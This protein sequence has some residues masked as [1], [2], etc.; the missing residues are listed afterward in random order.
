ML[1]Q[2][3]I[4]NYALIK[5]LSI[6]PDQGLNIVTGE[7]GAGKSIMLGALG[8]LL[9]KRADTKVLFDNSRKCVIEGIFDV[10]EYRLKA[11]FDEFDVDYDTECILRREISSSGKSRAFVNDGVV[12]LDFLKQLGASLMDIHSQHDTLL[13]GTNT[14]QL[15]LID[16]FAQNAD[17][18]DSYALQYQ[19]YQEKKSIHEQLVHESAEL[20][21][22]ADY[23]QFLFDELEKGNFQAGEQEE[24]EEDLAKLENAEEIKTRLNEALAIADQSEFNINNFVLDLKNSL[25][26]I[27]SFSSNYESL[28]DRV[29]SVLIE[30]KDI[31]GELEQEEGNVEYDPT[32]TE[33]VQERLSLL[34]KLQQKHQVTDIDALRKIQEALSD[35]VLRVENLDEA[36][37]AADAAQMK[38]LTKLNKLGDQLSTS[39]KKIFKD[40]QA[41]IQEL[42][43]GLGMP[44]AR[45]AIDH[46]NQDPGPNGKDH[47]NLLFSANKGVAPQALKTAASGGE[48]SRLMFA[49]KYILADKTALP[50]I[51]FDE[52][53]AGIS[54]EVAI[55][56]AQMMTVMA[57][58]HQVMTITHLPQIAA[59]GSSHYFVFKD[60]AG[61]ST[62]SGIRK[63]SEEERLLEIAQMIGGKSPS[64]KTIESAKELLTL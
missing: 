54:G 30:L 48:F 61:E 56:M 32:R 3:S 17:L 29:E 36:I 22:E 59:K 2:L 43:A 15:N 62:A 51:V 38:A 28:R 9:G 10:S 46:K 53:D 40:F 4:S 60:D 23:N 47:I 25:N 39:R 63:L 44:N 19:A 7:T 64:E 34:Y 35:E 57:G 18:K 6:S 21:K 58:N 5:E 14:F 31:T 49:V 8:L 26:Q 41:Q 12:N 20:R 52:I 13:L 50:T 37:E 45:L 33:A 55:Q 11:L 42:L 16:A 1:Q 27:S 24:M